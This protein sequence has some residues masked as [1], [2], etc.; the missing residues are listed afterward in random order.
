MA[1]CEGRSDGFTSAT[2]KETTAS[3]LARLQKALSANYENAEEVSGADER[4]EQ[5]RGREWMIRLPTP[6]GYPIRY[7]AGA[8]YICP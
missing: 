1:L 3:M 4:S 7:A 2:M 8:A 6:S 5:I